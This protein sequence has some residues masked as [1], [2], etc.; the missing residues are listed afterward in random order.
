MGLAGGL[1]ICGTVFP[2][3]LPFAIIAV[4][5]LVTLHAVRLHRRLD[6]LME[7]LDEDIKRATERKQSD[8]NS[9]G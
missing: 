5:G 4:V 1:C 7:L 6:A 2:R 9:G 3:V 8:E